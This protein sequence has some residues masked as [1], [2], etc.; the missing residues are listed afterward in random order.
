MSNHAMLLHL[1]KGM[2][3]AKASWRGKSVRSRKAGGLTLGTMRRGETCSKQSD[4]KIEEKPN[5]VESVMMRKD[6]VKIEEP[7]LV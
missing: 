5:Y 4:E 1:V 2:R 3:I 6:I 7:K